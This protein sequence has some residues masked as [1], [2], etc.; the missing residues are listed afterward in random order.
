VNLGI[1]PTPERGECSSWSVSLMAHLRGVVA[2]QGQIVVRDGKGEK[3]RAVP[4]P[5]SL[6][7]PLKG[8]IATAERVHA[9][10]LAEGFG[11]VY[12]PYALAR[13][14]PNA[15]REPGWQWVFPV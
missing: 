3:D 4:L 10:D 5:R 7:E 6:V 14:Y 12:L 1:E 8:Q 2:A 11:R 15:D 9:C 13:K